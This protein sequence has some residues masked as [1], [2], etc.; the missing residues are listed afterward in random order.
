M[1]VPKAID[2][3]LLL[4]DGV[5]LLKTICFT[6]ENNNHSKNKNAYFNSRNFCLREQESK[7][8]TFYI[9]LTPL[10][11]LSPTV[12]IFLGFCVLW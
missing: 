8:S 1:A 9:Y 5:L 11:C 4:V 3:G 6:T 2:F 7:K 10:L 12:V